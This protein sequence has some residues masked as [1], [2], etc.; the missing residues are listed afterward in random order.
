MRTDVKIGVT[1]ILVVSVGVLLYFV[2]NT[3]NGASD[4]QPGPESTPPVGPFNTPERPRS[5]LI[6]TIKPPAAEVERDVDVDVASNNRPSGEV[7]VTEVRRP[8]VLNL[9]PSTR[10]ANPLSRPAVEARPPIITP[11]V[12]SPPAATVAASTT[13]EPGKVFTD[14]D[15]KRYYVVKQGDKGLWAVAEEAYN[16]GR[17][18]H[19]LAQANPEAARSVLRPG[20]KILLPDAPVET[21]ARPVVSSGGSGMTAGQK[22]YIVKSGD[23]G[24][25]TIARREYGVGTLWPAIARANPS[26]D[27]SRLRIGQEIVLPSIEEARRMLGLSG[28]E[29]SAGP[30]ASSSVTTRP[31]SAGAPTASPSPSPSSPSR[32]AWD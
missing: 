19:L 24:Y 18:W 10:P 7:E 27:S 22:I 26:V 23:L 16:D 3:G 21:A 5:P 15:G 11:P 2:L 8:P 28:A 13:A 14:T 20:Q 29:S 17:K 30:A 25:E 31:A 1:A 32:R 9:G 4:S 6:P 12:I